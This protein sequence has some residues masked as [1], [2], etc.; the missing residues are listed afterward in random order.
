[1][2]RTSFYS[3]ISSRSE[4]SDFV[5][6]SW[7]EFSC[8][9]VPFF[10]HSYNIHR[11]Y[12]LIL[13]TLCRCNM[14]VKTTDTMVWGNSSTEGPLYGRTGRKNETFSSHMLRLNHTTFFLLSLPNQIKMVIPQWKT[15]F[16]PTNW[17]KNKR[18]FSQIHWATTTTKKTFRLLL[19]E[20]QVFLAKSGPLIS[21]L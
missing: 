7:T 20:M 16:L 1:M 17:K 14:K 2:T 5:H 11:L 12:Y 4:Q 21:N 13:W 15:N 9:S 10:N 18:Y 6:S 8:S 19:R 3:S